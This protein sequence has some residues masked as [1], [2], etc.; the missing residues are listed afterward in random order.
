MLFVHSILSRENDDI[1]KVVFI[2]RAKFY[3]DN[4][5]ICEDNEYRST[6]FD[7]INTAISFGIN[8]EVKNMVYRGHTY[9]RAHWRDKIWKRAWELEDIFWCIESRC[10]KSLELINSICSTSRYLIW[11]QLSDKFHSLLKDCETMAKLI[12]HSSLL[13]TDDVRL[14]RLPIAYKFGPLCDHGAMDDSFHM[15]MQCPA[16]QPNRTSMFNEIEQICRDYEHDQIHI[17][18]NVYLTLMGKPGIGF[19]DGIMKDI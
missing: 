13:R 10:H 14:K 5:K 16:L 12:C 3:Y 15:V 11:W 1:A 7:L 2:E 9:N 4:I 6:V 8:E 17:H 18:N 19:T